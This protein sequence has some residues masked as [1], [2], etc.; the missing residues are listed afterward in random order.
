MYLR[1]KIATNFTQTEQCKLALYNAGKKTFGLRL[2]ISGRKLEVFE[3]HLKYCVPEDQSSTQRNLSG[4]VQK[5]ETF[6]LL[7]EAE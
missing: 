2:S 6:K 3:A 7:V 4:F 5:T 1:E